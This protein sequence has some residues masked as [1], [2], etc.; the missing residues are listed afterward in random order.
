MINIIG[1]AGFIGTRLSYRLDHS[2]KPFNIVDQ[3]ISKTYPSRTKKADVR[4]LEALRD[5]IDRSSV[6]INLAAVHR[7]DVRPRSLYD[8]VNIEGARNICQAAVEKQ[9]NTI[10]FTSSVAVYGF[11]RPGTDETGLINYYNDYG[12]TKW[13]AEKVYRSW[14]S[15]APSERTLVII[16]PTVVFGEQNRGNVYNLLHQIANGTFYMI[17]SGKNRKSMAYVEN[18]AAF[19]EY[20]L[21]AF[22]P[23]IHTFNYIDKPDYDMNTLVSEVRGYLGITDS[24]RVYIPYS[25]GYLTGL[26][27]DALSLITGKTYPISSIRVKKFCTTTQF[28]TSLHKSGFRPC[29]PISEGLKRTIS[30]E[31]I[32]DHSGKE[33]FYTE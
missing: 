32:E 15:E 28:E 12:R 27:F 19:L 1:G 6:L 24:R 20:T 30:Y 14:Q 13:E 16:R 25:L 31:F 10:I 9:C 2:R 7:D 17:G 26:Y 18:V 21:D 22:E 4:S 8:E 33:I 11:A 23:G 29:V 5:T 3:V